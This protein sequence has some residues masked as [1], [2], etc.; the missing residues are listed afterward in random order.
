M[1]N[2]D[3]VYIDLAIGMAVAFFLLSLIPSGLNEALA[4]VTRIRSKFLWAYINQLFTAKATDK[5]G[6]EPV[7]SAARDATLAVQSNAT[8]GDRA[9]TSGKQDALALPSSSGDVWRLMR[10]VPTV[11]P[12]PTTDVQVSENAPIVDLL[13]RQLMPIRIGSSISKNTKTTVKHVSPVSFAQALLEVFEAADPTA[14]DAVSSKIDQLEGT[15]VYTTIK[16]LWATSE[17]DLARFRTQLERWFDAEMARLS[18]LY[19]RLTRWILGIAAVLVVFAVN[20]DPIALGRDLWR[21]PDRRSALVEVAESTTSDSA[22]TDPALAA[23][24]AQCRKEETSEAEPTTAEAAAEFERARNCAVDAL[25]AQRK[26]GLLNASVF[27]WKTFTSSWSAG[28]QW[29][30]RPFK[31]AIVA[32]AIYLGAPFWYDTLRRLSGIR[33]ATTHQRET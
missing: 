15:P 32:F 28:W 18:G 17:N 14:P 12:R 20:V 1:P 8:V 31:L 9:T 19:K 7:G 2:L 26:I 16:A 30:L 33:R 27:E 13:H 24:L 10:A 5:A 3:S 22:T 29:L 21:D 23:L 6:P 11:D 4:F 25:E